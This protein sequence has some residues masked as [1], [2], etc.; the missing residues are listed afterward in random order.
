MGRT[1][2]REEACRLVDSRLSSGLVLDIREK[3][4]AGWIKTIRTASGLTQ[5]ELAERLRISQPA[6]R[7]LE[8]SEERGSLSIGRLGEVA[9][10]LGCTL[11]YALVPNRETTGD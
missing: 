2:R 4:D 6:V 10:A 8:E 11:V 1:Q 7:K 5:E 3:P 9:A